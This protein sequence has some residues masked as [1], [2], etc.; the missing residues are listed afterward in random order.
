MIQIT[1]TYEC[2]LVIQKP[3]VCTV[4][5]LVYVCVYIICT[6]IVLVKATLFIT[7]SAFQPFPFC[8]LFKPPTKP[9]NQT[10]L[11]LVNFFTICLATTLKSGV[12]YNIQYVMH[13]EMIPIICQYM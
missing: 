8:A 6:N 1:R 9:V 2:I 4:Y 7:P 13:Y 10:L 5:E 11:K 3:P 12:P